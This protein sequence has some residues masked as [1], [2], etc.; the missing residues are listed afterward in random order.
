M[1]TSLQVQPFASLVHRVG[2]NVPRLLINR[3]VVGKSSALERML[4]LSQ[5]FRFGENDNYRD[6]GVTGGD[7]QEGVRD[8]VKLLGWTDEFNAFKKAESKPLI[9][10]WREK[11]KK[12]KNAKT[13]NENKRNVYIFFEYLLN[14]FCQVLRFCILV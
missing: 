4:G 10:K 6:V 1:G 7:L 8:F 5:G 11:K 9:K 13:Q 14:E 12:K 3:E 2:E